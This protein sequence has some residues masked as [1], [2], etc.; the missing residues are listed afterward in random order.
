M[1]AMESLRVEMGVEGEEDF[2][3]KFEDV[4]CPHKLAVLGEFTW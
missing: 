4:G 2:R 3:T 1:R